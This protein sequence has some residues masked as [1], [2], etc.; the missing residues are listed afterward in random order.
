[1]MIDFK[2]ETL[3]ELNSSIELLRKYPSSRSDIFIAYQSIKSVYKYVTNHK[4]Y[5]KEWIAFKEYVKK[6]DLIWKQ[7]FND[8]FTN[9]QFDKNTNRILRNV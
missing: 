1:M 3:K 8:Y 2:E 5:E 9:Y 4:V 6:T 7:E